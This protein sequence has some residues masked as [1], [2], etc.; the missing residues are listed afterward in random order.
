M[1]IDHDS[2]KTCE[3]GDAPRWLLQASNSQYS[4]TTRADAGPD[5]GGGPDN[6]GGAVSLQPPAVSTFPKR[7]RQGQSR[8]I[9]EVPP[10]TALIANWMTVNPRSTVMLAKDGWRVDVTHKDAVRID[11]YDCSRGL[12]IKWRR[13]PV[14]GGG[15]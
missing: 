2:M 8:K 3:D 1:L 4:E 14:P 6:Q 5:P 12:H 11:G 13:H 15:G 9:A 7:R 10:S